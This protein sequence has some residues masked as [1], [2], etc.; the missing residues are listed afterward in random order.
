MHASRLGTLVGPLWTFVDLSPLWRGKA[1]G[2]VSPLAFM[3]GI[4]EEEE[5]SRVS[6]SEP[7]QYGSLLGQE[8]LQAQGATNLQMPGVD[9][10]DGKSSNPV[11]T[12]GGVACMP[13]TPHTY[14]QTPHQGYVRTTCSSGDAVCAVP[15]AVWGPVTP[16]VRGVR[17]VRTAHA[18]SDG[19]AWAASVSDGNATTDA[20]D[21]SRADTP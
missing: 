20:G 13:H 17:I 15:S 14:Y 11:F 2:R 7:E 19:C 18:D 9:G 5:G 6:G 4:N 3:E 1:I 21:A 10:Q 8:D 16:Y 12:Q